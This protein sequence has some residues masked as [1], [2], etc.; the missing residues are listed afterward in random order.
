M[1]FQRLNDSSALD[2]VSYADVDQFRESERYLHAESIPLTTV[3]FSVRRA[4]LALPSCKL[5]LV[6]SFPRIINGYELSGRLVVVIP[7]DDVS[8]ARINGEL[9]GSSILVLKGSAQC[10]VYEP[11]GRLVAIL[12]TGQGALRGRALDFDRGYRLIRLSPHERFRLQTRIAGMLELAA[13]EPETQRLPTVRAGLQKTLLAAIDRALG[14]GELVD[15]DRRDLLCRYKTIIDRV[16]NLIGH[17]P[18]ADFS[19]GQL[20][21]EIGVSVRTLQTATRMTCGSGIHHYGRLRRLWLVRRQL[22]SGAAGLTVK[23]SAL[24]H[25]FCHMGEFSGL[26]RASFGELPS[27]TLA[28]AQAAS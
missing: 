1:L 18:A 7:M 15:A 3:N 10:T 27:Q 14:L 26:Y 6:R 22:R 24:A 8:S 13:R 4:N 23:A 16:D 9:I 12:S 19:C 25:G 2:L 21:G 17:N 28:A 11:E 20:A 5:S